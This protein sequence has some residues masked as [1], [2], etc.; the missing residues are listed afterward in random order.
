MHKQAVERR[1]VVVTDPELLHEM[2]EDA[3]TALRLISKTE[4]AVGIL[5][6]RHDSCRYTLALDEAVP[7]GETRELSLSS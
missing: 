6:T 7:H 5:V 3:E 4:R 1:E 2:L